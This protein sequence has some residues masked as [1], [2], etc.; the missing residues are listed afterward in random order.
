[1]RC[2]IGV[3]AVVLATGCAAGGGE[4]LPTGSP[5]VAPPT[6]TTPSAAASPPRSDAEVTRRLR[7]ALLTSQDLQGLSA[8]GRPKDTG[9]ELHLA[10]AWPC[11]VQHAS[12]QEVRQFLDRQFPVGHFAIDEAIVAYTTPAAEAIVDARRYL[13][14]CS[15]YQASENSG[16]FEVLGP[17]PVP[18][19]AQ[20]SDAFA[21]CEKG[22]GQYVCTGLVSHRDLLSDVICAGDDL[23]E[24]QATIRLLLPTAAARLIS[25]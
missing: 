25:A 11:N 17:L 13:G 21:F 18:R 9:P 1:M 15:T 19:P 7:R 16:T 5:V 23:N 12:D 24:V 14:R 2:A 20:V 22:R 3:V 6:G 10:P 4:A 8:A